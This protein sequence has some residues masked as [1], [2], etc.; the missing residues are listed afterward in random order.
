MEEHDGEK[1]ARFGQDEG[2]IVD[3]AEAGVAERGCERG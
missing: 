3:M 1:L 2:Q